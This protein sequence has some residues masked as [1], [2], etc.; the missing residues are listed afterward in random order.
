MTYEVWTADKHTDWITVT[1]GVHTYQVWKENEADAQHL[2]AE[3][4]TLD[5]LR[6]E[7]LARI[8]SFGE[9]A[10]PDSFFGNWERYDELVSILRAAGIDMEAS[11]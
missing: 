8:K 6:T 10:D 7:I 11:E 1:D 3:L 4:N 2:A 5:T 9:Y